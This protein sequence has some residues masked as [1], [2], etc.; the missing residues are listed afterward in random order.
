MDTLHNLTRSIHSLSTVYPYRQV[1]LCLQLLTLCATNNNAKRNRIGQYKNGDTVINIVKLIQHPFSNIQADNTLSLGAQDEQMNSLDLAVRTSGYASESVWILS[2]NSGNH[3][4]FVGAD[5]VKA[6]RRVIVSN[7]QSPSIN[8]AKMWSLAALQNLAASY[9][10]SPTGHC[11]WYYDEDDEK[12]KLHSKTPLTVDGLKARNQIVHDL[13]LVHTITTLACRQPSS[14][15]GSHNN[16]NPW[17]SRAT[18]R[19]GLHELHDNMPTW[20]AVGAIKNL[21]LSQDV[22]PEIIPHKHCLCDLRYSAD[23][24]VSEH[25]L[26]IFDPTTIP[27]HIIVDLYFHM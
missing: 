1:D 8:V 6:L 2:F 12:I 18:K 5:G 21:I 9:C 11:R 24:L 19:E 20:A 25:L 16:D 3:D 10:D 23:W 27:P 4:L 22:W 14:S 26:K 17:P 15:S 13:D 7:R